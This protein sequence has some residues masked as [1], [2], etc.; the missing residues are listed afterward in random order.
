MTGSL[1]MFT[2]LESARAPVLANGTYIYWR[3]SPVGRAKE[4]NMRRVMTGGALLLGTLFVCVGSVGCAC[5]G[6]ASA[7]RVV[8][9]TPPQEEPKVAGPVRPSPPAV[10]TAVYHPEPIAPP[11]A[12]TT[13]AAIEDLGQKYPG[14]F[15]YDDRKG[16]FRFN[17]DLLF[18]SGSTVVK[19]GPK[20]ALT[21]LAQ[22]LNDVQA[23]DR[24]MIIIGHTDSDRVI[25]PR[26]VANLK[27][28]GKPANNLG[29]SEARAESVA[30]V[31]QAGG[32]ET[33]RMV[34][35]G[36]G[37]DEPIADNRTA[38]G[39]ARNRHVA[40]FLTPMGVVSPSA[41]K[42]RDFD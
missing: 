38:E 17:S 33:S 15:V 6:P 22:I 3:K 35:G 20:A 25:K 11:A 16:M 41:T 8:I 42:T 31:L 28:L 30:A 24:S 14:L 5:C 12:M 2:A 27:K 7:D 40:I 9:T 26:T 29:L 13:K 21:R 32:I 36:K 23:K 37:E 10:E 19:P 4:K 39:K 18:D 1:I 34:T